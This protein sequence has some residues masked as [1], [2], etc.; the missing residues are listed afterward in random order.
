[1]NILHLG[2]ELFHADGRTGRQA[3]RRA[4]RQTEMMKLIVAFS[5]FAKAPKSINIRLLGRNLKINLRLR[6]KSCKED[7]WMSD[8]LIL[9]SIGSDN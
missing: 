2:T 3:E 1:M 9:F 8:G 6:E 7:V 4:D 5:S